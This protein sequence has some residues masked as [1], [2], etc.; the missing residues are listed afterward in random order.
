[1]YEPWEMPLNSNRPVGDVTVLATREPDRESNSTD[2][3]GTTAPDGSVITPWNVARNGVCACI[4][5]AWKHR[6]IEKAS[7]SRKV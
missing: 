7:E 4:V 5:A 6:T 3:P 2:A 1:M